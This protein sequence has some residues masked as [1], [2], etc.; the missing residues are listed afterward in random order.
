MFRTSSS[1][2]LAV[3]SALV[4]SAV[5]CAKTG[6]SSSSSP[7][8]SPTS[9]PSSSPSDKTTLTAA[10]I[11]DAVL[12]NDGPAAAK[13]VTMRRP[14]TQWSADLRDVQSKINEK[15]TASPGSFADSMQS[16]DPVKVQSAL[17]DLSKIAR[18][19]LDDRFGASAV[20]AALGEFGAEAQIGLQRQRWVELQ[21]DELMDFPI[22]W[23]NKAVI[24]A[25]LYAMVTWVVI[26]GPAATWK[27]TQETAVRN[28]A[29]G[30]KASA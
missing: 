25:V 6:T 4:F 2:A 18:T 26:T 24:N 29:V 1:I 10:Q 5:G 22:D 8:S 3:A 12:F 7:T 9:S 28:I 20:D 13:L 19:V 30:L 27:L 21:M 16:G 23:R 14:P 17:Q 15:L 11:S